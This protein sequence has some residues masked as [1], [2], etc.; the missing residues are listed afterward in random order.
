MT[1]SASAR[2]TKVLLVDDHPVVREGLR[3]LLAMEGD[4]EV[5]GEADDAPAAM[6]LARQLRPDLAIVD[7]SLRQ[8]NGADLIRDLA[9][10]LPDLKTL[11]LS[12]HN[13]PFYAERVFRLGARGYITKGEL[14]GAVI[15]GIRAVLAGKIFVSEKAGARMAERPAGD[16]LKSGLSPTE[17]LSKREFEVFE[18]FGQGLSM[19][20]IAA[21]LG[22][23][24]K[25]VDAHRE[26]IKAK[27]GLS[28]VTELLKIAI[29]W[30]MEH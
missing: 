3:D 7:L 4:L 22:V 30:V 6:D 11:V 12:M 9:A 28:S 8:S 20:D 5:C 19:R 1:E 18:L 21:R 26:N 14:S 10:M 13:D 2:R 15:Q 27:M 23:S 24:V 17:R 29:Q 25:T 16:K